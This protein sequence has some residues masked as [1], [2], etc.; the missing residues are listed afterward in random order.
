MLNNIEIKVKLLRQ[1]SAKVES[2][3]PRYMSEGASGMDVFAALDQPLVLRA[4][5]REL[6]PCG[7]Q[8]EIPPGLEAQIRPRSG[9]AMKHGI[10]CLNAPGTIDWDYRGEIAVILINLGEDDFEILPGM[11]VAQ[12]IFQ[13]VERVELRL[14]EELNDS[15]RGS[16]GF[17]STGH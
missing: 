5:K 1:P 9:L 17:G 6:I 11:R 3:L 13:K 2:L 10:T 12:M 8:L 7:F 14:V 16:G 15:Q 4:G